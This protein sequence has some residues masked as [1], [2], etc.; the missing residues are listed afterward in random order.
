[1]SDRC[2]MF[3]ALAFIARGGHDE[4]SRLKSALRNG[5]EDGG[6]RFAGLCWAAKRHRYDLALVLYCPVDAL[7]DRSIRSAAFIAQYFS[8]EQLGLARHAISRDTIGRS[9]AR[10]YSGA[11]GAMA[12]TI[13]L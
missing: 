11:M 7:Q 6:M 5:L 1:M 9:R 8:N 4:C 12:I 3:G 13:L 2:D 10:G